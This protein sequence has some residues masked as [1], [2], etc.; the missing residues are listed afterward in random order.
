VTPDEA[1]NRLGPNELLAMADR[2]GVPRDET[3]VLWLLEVKPNVAVGWL[4]NLRNAQHYELQLTEQWPIGN[5]TIVGSVTTERPNNPKRPILWLGDGED[6]VRVYTAEL[7]IESGRAVAT[8]LWRPLPDGLESSIRFQPG[9]WTKSG[10]AKV[11]AEALAW[12]ESLPR[13]GGGRP[14]GTKDYADPDDYRDAIRSRI[15][16]APG[17]VRQLGAAKDFTIARW[18]GI[19]ART[20]YARNEEHGVS[21]KGIRE[22]RV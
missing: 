18:L 2:Y 13:Q 16:A 22:Q 10:D 8:T 1:V 5:L 20:M 9:R 17:R 14:A 4:C 12:L 7:Q 21:M 11:A 15:Y 3:P 19:S 6:G